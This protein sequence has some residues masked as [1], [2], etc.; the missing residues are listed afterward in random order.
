MPTMPSSA[1]VNADGTSP[2]PESAMYCESLVTSYSFLSSV[3]SLTSEPANALLALKIGRGDELSDAEIRDLSRR[4]LWVPV[5]LEEQLGKLMHAD[6][7]SSKKI[8][9]RSSTRGERLYGT[10]DEALA[11]AVAQYGK[12]LPYSLQIFILDGDTINAEALPGGYVYVTRRAAAEL[13]PEELAFVLGHEVGHIAKRHTGKQ[14]QQRLVETG[15]AKELLQKLWN[16]PSATSLNKIM[17]SMKVVE[18]LQG[19][20]ASYGKDQ[21]SESD[22]CSTRGMVKASRDPVAA[23]NGYLELK[24]SDKPAESKSL[25]PTFTTHPSSQDR[26]AFVGKVAKHY[27][28]QKAVVGTQ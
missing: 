17:T 6:T 10:A 4:Y 12:D 19:N 13:Q 15:I 26:A 25:L 20:V 23:M 16:N 5:T 8:L 7:V 3:S 2:V 9:Q 1:S 14:L 28:Q 22:A 21:E 11:M 27:E 18:R 24:G